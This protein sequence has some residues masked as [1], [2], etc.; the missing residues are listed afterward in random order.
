MS[1]IINKVNLGYLGSEYQYQLVST[2][3]NDPRFFTELFDII[4]QNMFTEVYLKKVV[5]IMKDYYNKYGLVPKYDMILLKMRETAN[6]EDDTE[7]CIEI[8]NKL[9]AQTTDGIE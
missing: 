5:G 4:D 1:K 3:I 6:T 2:F 9:K 7:Y 8:I